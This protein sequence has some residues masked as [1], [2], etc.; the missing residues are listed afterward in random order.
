MNSG[1]IYR[2]RFAP[3]PTGPLHFGS[4][5]AATG[6]YLHA[7]QARGQWLVRIEDLDPP[8]TVAGAIDQILY[9]LEVFGFEW[10][11]PVIYQSQRT[12]AYEQA[13]EELKRK[14]L[15][16][17]CACTRSELQA[18][19]PHPLEP[20]EE[21]HYPGRCRLGPIR[22]SDIYAWRFRVPDEP[23]RFID[24]IQGEQR[25]TLNDSIG[26]FVIKRRDGL[27]AYQ[28]AVVVD[29]AA[30][31]ITDVVRGAD[32][33]SN[34]PRQ[35]ALQHALS[36]PTPKYS[37]LPVAT[38]LQGLKLSKSTHAAALSLDQPAH[39]LW[40]VLHFLRQDPPT[41]LQQGS[42]QTLWEWAFAHWNAQPLFGPTQL[43]LH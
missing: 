13:F 18:L 19:Q 14:E 37:H 21:L 15:I 41:A 38:D 6:S 27:F 28:L 9:A 26:D 2:G 16:Y 33:L 36:L 34:T 4:L 17:P 1:G 22:H 39:T 29:D 3:S 42:L 11:E 40:Q 10:D 7:R 12:T 31:H 20:H 5:V 8:R 25:I 32:L 23:I 30:Q 35:I 43:T 24:G